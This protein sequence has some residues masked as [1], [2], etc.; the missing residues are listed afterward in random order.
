[1]KWL[2]LFAVGC[3]SQSSSPDASIH[4]AK[5]IDAPIIDAPMIDAPPPTA[6]TVDCASS[7]P[8]T[9]VTATTTL[10]YTYQFSSGS[11]IAVNDVVMFMMPGIHNVAPFGTMTDSGLRVDFGATKCLK[12]TMA[13]TFNFHCTAHPNLQGTITVN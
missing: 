12:F 2:V 1:M 11:T 9:T 10:P 13:G 6:L 3:S 4:D 8:V 5:A 7:T